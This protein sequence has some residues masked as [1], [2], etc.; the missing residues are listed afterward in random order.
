[1]RKLELTSYK[2]SETGDP[3]AEVHDYDV[4][5]SVGEVL[6]CKDQGLSARELLASDDLFRKIR[7]WPEDTILLEEAEYQR[8]KQAFERLTGY[9]RFDV[10]M[11]RR[12]LDCPEVEVQEKPPSTNGAEEQEALPAAQ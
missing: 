4:R 6:L 5:W 3:G 9:Q 11:V 8:L 7:D 12:V 10:E 1:M 2:V